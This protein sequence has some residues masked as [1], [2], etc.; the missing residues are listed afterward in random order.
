MI[1]SCKLHDVEPWSWLRD[2]LQRLPDITTSRLPELL[3]DR[4]Q[5]SRPAAAPGATARS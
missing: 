3:P 4:W 1:A 5:A 2:V